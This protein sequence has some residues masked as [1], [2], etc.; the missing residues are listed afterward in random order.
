MRSDLSPQ[1][2]GLSHMTK[3]CEEEAVVPASALDFS[4]YRCGTGM[5]SQDV[6]CEPAQDGEV[7]GSIVHSGPIAV[8]VEVDVEHPVQLVLDGPMTARDRDRG[9]NRRRRSRHP[10]GSPP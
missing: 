7:L 1:A 5:G 6:E 10:S 3:H 2:A 4:A 9:G 8:L